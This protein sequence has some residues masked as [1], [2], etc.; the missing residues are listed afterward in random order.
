[1]IVYEGTEASLHQPPKPL[2]SSWDFT[3]HQLEPLDKMNK[4]RAWWSYVYLKI[5]KNTWLG[6][7][8]LFLT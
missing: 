2:Q 3:E 7:F 6:L 4:I 1:M 5:S 8:I